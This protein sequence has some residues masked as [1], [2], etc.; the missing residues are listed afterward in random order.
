MTLETESPLVE[1]RLS[2]KQIIIMMIIL[3]VM[4]AVFLT[5]AVTLA[6]VFT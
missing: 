1:K 6:S 2:R 5:L 3:F 4:A